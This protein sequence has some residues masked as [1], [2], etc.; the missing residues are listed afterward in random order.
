[1]LDASLMAQRNSAAALMSEWVRA[2]LERWRTL[3]RL[4]HYFSAHRSIGRIRP[5]LLVSV[6]LLFPLVVT[7]IQAKNA[8]LGRHFITGQH[9]HHLAAQGCKRIS[10]RSL[11]AATLPSST[12]LLQNTSSWPSFAQRPAPICADSNQHRCRGAG[13]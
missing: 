4:R 2:A 8:H 12:P 5:E 9:R 7:S 13:I 6:N 1:M 10:A 11:A 3:D